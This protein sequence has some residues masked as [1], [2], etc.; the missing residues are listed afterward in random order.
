[1]GLVG[2]HII[3]Q[4]EHV[5][6]ITD[7]WEDDEQLCKKP[8]EGNFQRVSSCAELF[9]QNDQSYYSQKLARESISYVIPTEAGSITTVSNNFF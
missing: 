6:I 7:A 2:H 1:M 8:N 9:E 5:H 4:G 3:I